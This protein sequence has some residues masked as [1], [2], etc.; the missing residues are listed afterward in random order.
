MSVI[1]T[2]SLLYLQQTSL[3]GQS[4]TPQLTQGTQLRINNNFIQIENIFEPKS[5]K[6]LIETGP[7]SRRIDL[8]AETTEIGDS[9]SR[10][11]A[12]P[13]MSHHE[14]SVSKIANVSKT[15][16]ARDDS[17]NKNKKN[18]PPSKNDKVNVESESKH[19]A[20]KGDKPKVNSTT[21]ALPNIIIVEKNIKVEMTNNSM[22]NDIKKKGSSSGLKG[23]AEVRNSSVGEHAKKIVLEE[24][25]YKKVKSEEKAH[26]VAPVEKALDVAPEQSRKNTRIVEH[27]K[28]IY[29]MPL[30]YQ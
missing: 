28:L 19:T 13:G 30:L 27:T 21:V 26:T 8:D 7:Q 25:V 15:E 22:I 18:V 3:Y 10:K 4:T 16:K 9:K 5:D 11:S 1:M 12:K 24:K 23:N 14:G 6:K 17:S 29:H 20:P 2:S